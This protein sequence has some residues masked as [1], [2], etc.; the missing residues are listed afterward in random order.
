MNDLRLGELKVLALNAAKAVLVGYPDDEGIQLNSGRP[1]ASLAPEEIRKILF[2]MTPGFESQ[3]QKFIFDRGPIDLQQ[4]LEKRHAQAQQWAVQS[5]QAAKFHIS[6]GGGHDYGY[7]DAAA[8]LESFKKSKKKPVVINFDAHFD[9]RPLDKGLTSG[10]PF[11]RLF[12]NAPVSF[13]FLEV[14]IQ[15]HCNSQEHLQWLKN[16]KAHIIFEKD[17]RKKSLKH[18]LSPYLKKWRGHP[19]FISL[20]I[21]VFS[22]SVAP[23][24][25][26]AWPVG[27]QAPDFFQAWP[28]IFKFLDVKGLGLYEVS[29][30]LDV[31]LVTSRLAA[32]ILHRTFQLK[33]FL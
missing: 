25:S 21:D 11:Y 14:G 15:E 12:E 28:E 8:F 29:P 24:C 10:T 22:S 20:D 19:T 27:L 23:G 6:L 26:Q 13:H 3:M 7:P 2:R 1:G 4:P 31:S 18:A 9:V 16:K 30:P 17:L 32:L 33:G 5:Y